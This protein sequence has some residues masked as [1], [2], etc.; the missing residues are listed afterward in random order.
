[1][2]GDVYHLRM[3][4][5]NREKNG[6][7]DQFSRFGNLL[8]WVLLKSPGVLVERDNCFTVRERWEGRHVKPSY[9]TYRFAEEA[10]GERIR[11]E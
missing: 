4:M 2:E 5:L 6:E 1:M 3:T 8:L 9:V 11:V 10:P 7:K